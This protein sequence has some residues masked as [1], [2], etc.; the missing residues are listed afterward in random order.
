MCRKGEAVLGLFRVLIIGLFIFSIPAALITTNVRVALSEKAVYDYS[1]RTYDASARSGIPESE[2]L[3]ANGEIRRYL[4][5]DDAR[6]LAIMVQNTSGRQVSLFN[7]REIVHMADVRDLVR[8]LFN[9]QV[10]A[11]AAVLTLAVIMLVLWPPRALAAATLYGSLLTGGVLAV[12]GALAVS[13]F[14]AA[15]SQFHGIAFSN[16]LWKLNPGTDHLIQMFPEAFWERITTV[17]GG[18]TMLEALAIGS[19]SAVYLLRS[20]PRE[21][22]QAVRPA[23][24]LPG[25]AGH[26]RPL[27]PPN[28][29]HYVR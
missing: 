27:A 15:W 3:R 16:D 17:I 29:R 21:R 9:V 28:P 25:P 5:R 13:G 23:P 10:L 6:P 18:F 24:L 19:V 4:T 14:D 22:G 20:R 2:L 11:V 8:A 26:A 12:A 1:V 7:A